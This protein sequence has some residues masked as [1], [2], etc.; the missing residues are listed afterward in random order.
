M[1]LLPR[2]NNLMR[3]A[4]FS[5]LHLDLK[6]ESI[7]S[8]IETFMKANKLQTAFVTGDISN[9]IHLTYH[10][11]QLSK[12]IPEIYFTLGNHCYYFSSLW[13]VEDQVHDLTTRYSNLHWL[14]ELPPI[15]LEPDVCL[16][17][18]EGWTGSKP[19][20]EAISLE[21]FIVKE[22]NNGLSFKEFQLYKNTIL[23]YKL[24]LASQNYNKVI[25]LTHFPPLWTKKHLFDFYWKCY[26]VNG[27]LGKIIRKYPNTDITV[28][29]GHTH[30][31]FSYYSKN[32]RCH[33]INPSYKEL[34]ERNIITI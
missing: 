6:G 33:T 2:K 21:N 14:S 3:V 26:N 34:N 30:Q 24:S 5:D 31:N 25:L 22:F 18:S 4:Y 7:Y 1:N 12:V 9:G 16:I 27:D 11:K 19:G 29:S 15:E 10:L 17:G 23:E 28:Y 8:N 20:L 13:K 32:W